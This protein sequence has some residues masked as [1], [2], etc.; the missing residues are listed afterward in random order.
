MAHI[1]PTS[2]I[3]H[4]KEN[5]DANRF[6]FAANKRKSDAMMVDAPA[7]AP[8]K[9]VE[10]PKAAPKAPASKAGSF[11]K[12]T[13]TS[14]VR[15]APAAPVTAAAAKKAAMAITAPAVNGKRPAWDLKG[16]LEDM[17]SMHQNMVEQLRSTSTNLTSLMGQLSER[18]STVSTLADS[19]KALIENLQSQ[20]REFERAASDQQRLLDNI[21][22]MKRDH[23]QELDTAS[24]KIR[25]LEL[26]LDQARSRIRILTE[27]VERTRHTL[28]N[29][30]GVLHQTESTLATTK[31]DLQVCSS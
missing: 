6:G 19:K 12:P 18:N 9:K 8:K 29:T 2:L 26:D 27:D 15:G 7:P 16:R 31:S 11:S 10:P 25:T 4:S 3:D 14:R 28:E 1:P 13:A 24:S 17:E 22:Q 20:Q 21:S 5:A 30:Q 23:Q